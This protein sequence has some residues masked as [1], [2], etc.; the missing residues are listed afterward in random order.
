MEPE[1]THRM[2]RM[3]TLLL[4]FFDAQVNNV[5]GILCDILK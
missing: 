1:N 5:G 2:L 4:L 3:E